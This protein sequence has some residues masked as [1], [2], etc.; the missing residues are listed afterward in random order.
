MKNFIRTLWFYQYLKNLINVELKVVLHID[1]FHH[2]E[3]RTFCFDLWYASRH[4]DIH[5]SKVNSDLFLHGFI[6]SGV[7]K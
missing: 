1:I 6:S 2:L 4:Q 7:F 3:V 5:H